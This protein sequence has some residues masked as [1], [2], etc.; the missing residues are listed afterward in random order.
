MSGAKPSH[1]TKRLDGLRRYCREAE[2]GSEALCRILDLLAEMPDEQKADYFGLDVAWLLSEQTPDPQLLAASLATDRHLEVQWPDL[3][4]RLELD[5]VMQSLIQSTRVFLDH[6]FIEGDDGMDATQAE[7]SRRMLIALVE[8]LRAVLIGLAFRVV[9]LQRFRHQDNAERRRLALETQEVFAPLANRLGFASLKW[10][11]EDLA[12]HYLDPDAYKNLARKLE[13]KRVERERYLERFESQLIGLLKKEGV[14]AEISGRPKH[15]YSIWRKMQKKALSFEDL[16]DLLAVRLIVDKVSHCYGALGVVH[17]HWRYLP[18]EFDDYIANR[19]SNGYQS[20]HTAIV[21]PEGR[22]VEVQIRTREMHSVA[23]LGVAAHWKYKE[24]GAGKEGLSEQ[25]RSLRQMLENAPEGDLIGQL[26]AEGGRDHVFVLTPQGEIHELARGATPL[27]FAYSVHTQLG[28]RCRGAKVDG[29][30]VPLSYELKNG[31]RVEILAGKNAQPRRDWMNPN[32][33]FLA[34]TRARAKVRHWFKHLDDESNARDGHG[35]LDKLLTRLDAPKSSLEKLVRRFNF[36]DA[37]GLYAAIG[38]GEISEAQIIGVLKLKFPDSR[39]D[40]SA[41][42]KPPRASRKRPSTA[43]IEGAGGLLTQIARCCKP[44]PGDEIKGY[45]TKLRG[46][47]IHRASCKSLLRLEALQPERIL[48]LSWGHE[49]S[50]GQ[51]D[52]LVEALDRQG[53]LRDISNV[54]SNEKINMLG[55]N[56]QTNKKDQQARMVLTVEVSHVM[57]LNRLL[58]K[59]VQIPNVFLAR[60]SGDKPYNS[61]KSLQE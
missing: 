43:T 21:G 5:A 2:A 57:E 33:G 27:D 45:V 37:E 15:L 19:K 46:V 29:R 8:D 22:I 31:E 49:E 6:R 3:A 35:L 9:Q 24:A 38:R 48:E 61:K 4:A 55:A 30:I 51:V 59:L 23:E 50:K 60:R 42:K 53:L 41:G 7:R 52:I 58:D 39:A 1:W 13:Q 14:D 28:H 12:F 40:S 54:I 36:K 16:R 10:E 26:K 17:A 20:L 44:A 47:S 11:L 18:E 56:T 25:V 32:Y 34:T